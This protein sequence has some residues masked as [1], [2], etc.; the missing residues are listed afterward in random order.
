M[1]SAKNIYVLS[2]RSQQERKLNSTS[3][4]V[5][6]NRI[7][8]PEKLQQSVNQPSNNMKLYIVQC[9]NGLRVV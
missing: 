5:I 7:T 1:P 8:I 9:Q 4:T 2:N 3:K 6:K